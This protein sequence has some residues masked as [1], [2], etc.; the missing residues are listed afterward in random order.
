MQ[1]KVLT[2]AEVDFREWKQFQAT[3]IIRT[4][5]EIK[6]QQAIIREAEMRLDR[7]ANQLETLEN[8]TK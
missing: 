6:K 5:D 4:K 3:I 1:N 8:Q 7:L 2:Q